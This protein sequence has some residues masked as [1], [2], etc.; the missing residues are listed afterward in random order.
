[1]NVML[2]G[3]WQL[4]KFNL[5]RVPRSPP[6][7]TPQHTHTFVEKVILCLARCPPYF[8]DTVIIQKESLSET[9]LTRFT[10]LNQVI[11]S[12]SVSYACLKY[13]Y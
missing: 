10:W 2:D 11:V 4:T 7:L 3:W 13:L 9:I 1:M 8:P 5:Q 12:N 6:S